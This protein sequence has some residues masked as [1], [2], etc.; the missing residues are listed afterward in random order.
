M[1]SNARLLKSILLSEEVLAQ[2][3]SKVAIISPVVTKA[4]PEDMLNVKF[5]STTNALVI[6]VGTVITIIIWISLKLFL[7][8]SKR[9][10][11]LL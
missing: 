10:I 1:Y 3:E 6:E 9:V 11:S 7:K 5:D 8:T 2:L 4:T